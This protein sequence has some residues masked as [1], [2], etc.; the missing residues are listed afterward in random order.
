MRSNNIGILFRAY[1]HI[2]LGVGSDGSVQG[3][4]AEG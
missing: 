3:Q 2:Y 4:M 1:G